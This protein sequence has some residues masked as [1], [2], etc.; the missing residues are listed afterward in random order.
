MLTRVIR[1]ACWTRS[2]TKRD[3]FSSV[4]GP[5]ASTLLSSLWSSIFCT[6]AMLR[7]SRPRSSTIPVAG[8][9]V[10]RTVTSARN[11]WP[12]IS[13]LASPSV[14]PDNAWAASNRN[15]FVS[16]HIQKMQPLSDTKGL[17]RLHAEPPLRVTDAVV[18]VALG[19]GGDVRPIHR[20][21]REP[22]EGETGEGRRHGAGLRIDQFEFVALPDHE[23][24]AGLGADADPVDAVGHLDRAVGFEA[25]REAAGMQRIDQVGVH[26][27][28]RLAAGQDHI[29]V[30]VLSGPLAGNGVGE[31]VRRRIAAA[32]RAVGS[33]KIR[34]AELAGRA[35]AVLFAAAMR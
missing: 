12:W 14:V 23:F 25:D 34:V 20:L 5:S 27:Q 21:Q 33:D 17:V 35:G 11:E 4:G 3:R 28:Q 10:P 18:D 13:W 16:S 19:V 24:G 6:S 29:A 2:Q 9:G 31:I 7:W 1:P 22:L 32:E 30:S 15:D 8:S 26:L